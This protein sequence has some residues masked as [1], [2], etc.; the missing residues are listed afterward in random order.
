MRST[1]WARVLVQAPLS[2]RVIVTAVRQAREMAAHLR[3]V[4]Y[5]GEDGARAAAAYGG[6]GGGGGGSGGAYLAT[7]RARAEAD[8]A[9]ECAA[10]VGAAQ[11]DDPVGHG[12]C[13]APG[14]PPLACQGAARNKRWGRVMGQGAGTVRCARVMCDVRWI[15]CAF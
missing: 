5:D 6:G 15:F 12:A 10:A 9:A 11:W 1:L 7:L 14:E 2:V 3:D 4:D 13:A 8:A